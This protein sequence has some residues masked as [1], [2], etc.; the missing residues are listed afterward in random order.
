MV[1]KNLRKKPLLLELASF[2]ARPGAWR[3]CCI[4]FLLNMACFLFS[5]CLEPFDKT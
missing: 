2:T 5:V 3:V 1:S 4:A